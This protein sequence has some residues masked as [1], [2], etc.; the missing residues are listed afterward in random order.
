MTTKK[1]PSKLISFHQK[2]A[3]KAFSYSFIGETQG[4]L[5]A[6]FDGDDRRVYLGEGQVVFEAAKT[7]IQTWAMFPK[8]WTTVYYPFG[9][10]AIG[11]EV[12]VAI[13]L[14]GCWWHCGSR[15]VYILDTDDR[16]GFAYGT[17]TRHLEKGEELFVVEREADGKV[18]FRIRAFSKPNYWY[19]QVAYPFARLMQ[20]R[21]VR[22]AFKAML[23]QTRTAL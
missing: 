9:E 2:L 10:I 5:P 13:R 17:L 23:K 20:R 3:D 11:K 16:Y 8:S 6:G 19:V 12:A 22:H 1:S 4:D 21:F 7:A 15:I 14:L 18:Y